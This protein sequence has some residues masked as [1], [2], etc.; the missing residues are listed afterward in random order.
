[1]RFTQRHPGTVETVSSTQTHNMSAQLTQV[2]IS[3]MCVTQVKWS[4][5]VLRF[6][7]LFNMIS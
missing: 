5:C 4:Q 1:V 7:L 3:Q 2:C 6:Y